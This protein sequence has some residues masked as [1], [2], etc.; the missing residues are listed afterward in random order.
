MSCAGVV[1]LLRKMVLGFVILFLSG[2]LILYYAIRK[3]AC[4]TSNLCLPHGPGAS[5]IA[6]VDTLVVFFL[7][8]VLLISALWYH[9]S[10]E[11]EKHE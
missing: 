10:K 7:V 9:S 6:S 3:L 5:A 1:E 4:A 11:F 2:F 8:A